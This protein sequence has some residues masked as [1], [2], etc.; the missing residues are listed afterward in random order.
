MPLGAGNVDLT[1]AG[2][3]Y[4]YSSSQGLVI[5]DNS[6]LLKYLPEQPATNAAVYLAPGARCRRRAA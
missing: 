5:V 2:I 4:D 1:V 3:Y 6:T